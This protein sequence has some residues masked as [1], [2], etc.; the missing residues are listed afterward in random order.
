[1]SDMTFAREMWRHSEA[2]NIEAAK[3]VRAQWKYSKGSEGYG[4]RIGALTPNEISAFAEKH[5][6]D[7]IGDVTGFAR[8]IERAALIKAYT[9]LPE[10][11]QAEG[12][13]HN[14]R[15]FRNGVYWGLATYSNA[16]RVLAM[17]QT[18]DEAGEV[19]PEKPVKPR[20]NDELVRLENGP[21]TE[22]ARLR[23]EAHVGPRQF[24]LTRKDR[25]Y[26]NLVTAYAWMGWL[27]RDQDQGSN[28]GTSK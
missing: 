1:M 11:R 18:Q 14:R 7:A 22:A 28:G 16:I 3:D 27:A 5:M 10:L 17:G 6:P 2:G 24:D 12:A 25:S 21:A 19:V 13:K 8:A 23:F 20:K 9:L 4:E 26:I 15:Y